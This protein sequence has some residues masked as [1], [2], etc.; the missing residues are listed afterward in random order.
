MWS[1]DLLVVGLLLVLAPTTGAC[2]A[3]DKLCHPTTQSAGTSILT[4]WC[5]RWVACDASRG[6]VRDCVTA[7]MNEA[8]VRDETG[9]AGTCSEDGDFCARSSCD[10]DRVS[11]CVTKTKAVAC[12]ELT[13]G[14]VYRYPDFCDSCFR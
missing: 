6:A 5:E 12:T 9:C 4:A 10:E 2:D 11:E 8:Y 3:V 1:R 7:R 13:D 14:K